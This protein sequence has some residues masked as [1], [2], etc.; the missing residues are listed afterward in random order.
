MN[1]FVSNLEDY[2]CE[3][4]KQELPS[5]NCCPDIDDI[6]EAFYDYGTHRNIRISG[7]Y[8]DVNNPTRF[9]KRLKNLCSTL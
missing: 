9:Q 5:W 8:L 1:D 3:D 2:N 4:Q 6:P 7:I